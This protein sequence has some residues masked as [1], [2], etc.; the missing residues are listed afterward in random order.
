MSV[1]IILCTGAI[2]RIAISVDGFR[3]YSNTPLFA[4]IQL[5]LAYL[6]AIQVSLLDSLQETYTSYFQNIEPVRFTGAASV[7][8]LYKSLVTNVPGSA[9]GPAMTDALKA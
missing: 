3:N 8:A 2:E 9:P 6:V 7:S 1:Q 4:R 5:H